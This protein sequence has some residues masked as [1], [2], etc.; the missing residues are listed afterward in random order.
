VFLSLLVVLSTQSV[1]PRAHHWAIERAFEKVGE[2][3]VSNA[4]DLADKFVLS[5]RTDPILTSA[6]PS[7]GNGRV[8]YF[9][10]A[11]AYRD[12][13]TID[14]S[15]FL[16]RV[17]E[18]LKLSAPDKAALDHD[19]ALYHEGL[20]DGERSMMETMNPQP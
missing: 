8:S 1:D 14:A 11:D 16:E 20:A 3:A 12:A 17:A 18:R 9:V 6:W 15:A 13:V 19:C 7:V 4:K 10:C 2:E 5:M